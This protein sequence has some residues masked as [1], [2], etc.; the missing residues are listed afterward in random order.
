MVFVPSIA[1]KGQYENLVGLGENG[2]SKDW[3]LARAHAVTGHELRAGRAGE[4]RCEQTELA[5]AAHKT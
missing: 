5:E 4:G 1:K 3:T 2:E